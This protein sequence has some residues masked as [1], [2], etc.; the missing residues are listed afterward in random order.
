MW[1]LQCR[2]VYNHGQCGRCKGPIRSWD[3]ATRTVYA[4]E[5]C[6]PLVQGTDLDPE[7]AK[8]LAAATPVKVGR[9]GRRGGGGRAGASGRRGRRGGGIGGGR[10][11]GGEGGDGRG[12]RGGERVPIVLLAAATLAR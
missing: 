7:R 8:Q 1:Y 11:E 2:Y 5:T 9:G 12:G 3:M 6:Q 10:G 4:C